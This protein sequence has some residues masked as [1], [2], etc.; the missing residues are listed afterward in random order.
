MD[1][2]AKLPTSVHEEQAH[3]TGVVSRFLQLA[4]ERWV[5]IAVDGAPDLFREIRMPYP[6]RNEDGTVSRAEVG[7]HVNIMVS[8]A[9]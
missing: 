6:I 3:L 8:P 2:N 4:D 5:E 7:D 9:L 1:T